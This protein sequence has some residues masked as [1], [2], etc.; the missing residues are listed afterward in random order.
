[1]SKSDE[2]EDWVVF[3]GKIRTVYKNKGLTDMK[4]DL[5]HTFW[6]KAACYPQ[7]LSIGRDY[8]MMGSTVIQ[9]NDG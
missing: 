3:T 4:A 7:D 1:L 5:N 8:L 2:S 9:G 6:L